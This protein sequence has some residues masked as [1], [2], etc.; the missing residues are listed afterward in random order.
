M[1]AEDLLKETVSETM[2]DTAECFYDR[3]IL[4]LSFFGIDAAWL[5]LRAFCVIVNPYRK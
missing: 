1:T 2:L 4:P 5:S 3:G